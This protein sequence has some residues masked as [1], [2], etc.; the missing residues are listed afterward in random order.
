MALTVG[1][2]NL[3]RHTT[4]GNDLSVLNDCD[5]DGNL[6]VVGDIN[7]SALTVS[8]GDVSGNF[9][10]TGT[11]SI[12]VLDVSSEGRI[13]NGGFLAFTTAGTSVGSRLNSKT[14]SIASGVNQPMMKHNTLQD[15]TIIKN[16]LQPLDAAA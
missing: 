6:T 1:G 3:Y 14:Y 15:S 10:I 2:I 9:D 5:V 13:K 12:G 16:V 11:G 4:C 8:S 7:G